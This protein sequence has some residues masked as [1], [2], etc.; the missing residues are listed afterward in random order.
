MPQ[1]PQLIVDRESLGFGQEF[2][3]GVYIGTMKTDSIQIQNG[4]LEDLK[5]ESAAYTGDQAF[6]PEG[7]LKL[8]LK[9][10]ETTFIRVLFTP[11]AEK[12]YNGSI[13]IVSN[14]ETNATTKSSPMKTIGISGR[15][16]K[17]GDGG[18]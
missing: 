17:P 15:G 1:K 16:F 14:A 3:S 6:V 5:I 10:K 11:T 13:L 18:P 12:V 9:G 7:P 8:T 4:G 2:G